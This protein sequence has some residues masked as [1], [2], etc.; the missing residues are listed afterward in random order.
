MVIHDD[1]GW[2]LQT[3]LPESGQRNLSDW[4]ASWRCLAEQHPAPVTLAL[5]GG[6]VADRLGWAFAAGYQAA[7]RAA[8]P[9]GGMTEAFCATESSG[10]KPRDLTTALTRTAVGVVLDGAKSW[11]TFGAACDYL[12]VV[13][14]D[15][16]AEEQAGR[17]VLRVIRVPASAP[18]VAFTAQ[19]P[20]PFIS[21]VP[22]T[23][24]TFTGV[25]L[26]ESALLQGDGY[27][28]YLK[29]FRT[30]EDIHVT[31][32]MLAHALREVRRVNAAGDTAGLL[33]ELGV[34][35][36]ACAH[37]AAASPLAPSTHL[38]LETVQQQATALYG[39]VGE[40]LLASGDVAAARWQRDTPIFGV[41]GKA[42]ALRVQRAREQL[43]LT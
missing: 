4:L 15:P 9:G 25:T 16:A 5:R 13:A 8:F 30:I 29:P 28:D 23:A 24:V 38:L 36:A 32:A 31:L 11:S 43:G 21:E 34:C 18:G 1:L 37:L 35:L 2:L 6:F 41:A 19:S 20:L 7:M 3:R 14:R 40:R 12:L 26:P 17:P 10:Q 39:R 22:H 33:A 27:S 42:R